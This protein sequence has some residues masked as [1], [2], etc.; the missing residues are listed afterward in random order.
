MNTTLKAA[1]WMIGA[2]VSFSSMA[3]AGRELGGQLDTFEI[4]LYRSLFG[5]VVVAFMLTVLRRWNVVRFNRVGT[6]IFRN[7]AHFGG[8]NLWLFAVMAT[9]LAT[10]FA[11]EFTTPLWVILLSPFLLSERLTFVRMI[12]V[13]LGFTG[14][15]I[16]ARPTPDTVD[17][18]LIAAA[19]AAIFFAA[20]MIATKRLTRHE[21]IGS[22]MFWLTLIQAVL[23]LVAAGYDGTIKLPD[24]GNI[25][26]VLVVAAG[27]LTAHF[28]IT[29]ALAI[30]SASVVA[31]FDFVRLP[32]IAV[33]GMIL[34]NEPIEIW[35]LVG[36]VIIFAANYINILAENRRI[37]VA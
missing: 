27:G 36:A 31:P 16:V 12:A 7:A 18:G 28:C 15:L 11:L 6:H 33:V 8:Q 26:Y 22:I 14:I 17:A 10:V 34:Y 32:T 24:S 13:I 35:V 3:V 2:I 30:A 20:T 1:I 19:A 37:R 21:T 25:G 9:P 5:F 4:M 29:N 23:G